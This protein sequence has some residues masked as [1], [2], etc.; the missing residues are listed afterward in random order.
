[1]TSL[2]FPLVQRYQESCLS[3]RSLIFL[4]GLVI[5]QCRC[6]LW[7]EDIYLENVEVQTSFD[8]TFKHSISGTTAA[9]EPHSDYVGSLYEYS[10]RQLTYDSDVLNAFAGVLGV[11]CERMSNG[12]NPELEHA[13]GLPTYVFDWAILWEPNI[14]VHRKS[15]GWPSWSWC[16]WTGT[17]SMALTSMD[18]PQ[19]EDWLC[20]HTWIKWIIYDLN[21]QALMQ[22]PSESTYQRVKQVNN[23]FQHFHN[24]VQISPAPVP[25][26]QALIPFSSS[27]SSPST[28]NT[29]SHLLHFTT[30]SLSL[31]LMSA[32]HLVHDPASSSSRS[33]I[34][35]HSSTSQTS[36]PYGTIRINTT[37][38]HDPNP[39]R[40]YEFLVLSEAPR[41][42][43]VKNEFPPRELKSGYESEVGAEWAAY[44]VMLIERDSQ[45]EEVAERVG[46]GVVY[47]EAIDMAFRNEIGSSGAEWKEIWLR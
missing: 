23:R 43:V 1:M 26:V 25:K 12:R 4:E 30:L 16:G 3:Q 24:H 15:N 7:R 34:M 33:Y 38:H 28:T 29:Y 36:I 11:L 20:N 37:W 13:Y 10:S 5:F 31:H 32:S 44:F 18:V 6:A 47:R 9:G 2:R 22:I 14:S 45:N 19:L 35:Y 21:G 8:M 41:K 39:E 42:L 46:L 27:T 17:I 40:T